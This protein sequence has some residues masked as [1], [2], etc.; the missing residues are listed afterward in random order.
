MTEAAATTSTAAGNTRGKLGLW[1]CLALVVGNIIGSGIFLLPASLAPYGWNSVVGWAMTAAGAMFLA[2]VFAQLARVFPQAGGP[3]VYPRVAFGELCGFLMAWGYWVSTWVGNVSIAI[4]TVAS[5]AELI[6]ALKTTVGAPAVTAVAMI[7]V[8]TLLNYR[9]VKFAGAF[10]FV[11]TILKLLPLLAIIVLAVWLF[12]T[13]DASVI[14]VAPQPLS[15]SS[16]TAAATLTLWALLGLE[17][18]T[19]PSD[20]VIDPERTVPRATLWGTLLAAVIYVLACSTVVLLLPEAEL[21]K[22]NAPFADAI[23]LFWGDAAASTLAFF[24]FVSGLGAL[25]GWILL[26]GEMPRVLAAE[27]VFP[28]I[29][30]KESRFG[31]PGAAFFITSALATPLALM[32]YSRSMVDIFTFMILIATSAFLVMYLF[33]SL[34]A[35]KLAWNGQLGLAGRRLI[36]MLSVGAIATVYSIWTLYGAGSEA[37]WWT[38]VLLA[39]GLPVYYFVRKRP[40]PAIITLVATVMLAAVVSF[41]LYLKV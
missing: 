35:I 3:Y 13:H 39:A 30:A 32:N 28:R 18:A 16:V 11:T 20:K 10:Q 5:L 25:N 21:A 4:G 15:I 22:S 41:L 1:M 8:L 23:R 40:M 12:L 27:G 19:V 26:Q 36:W 17:S 2:V 38:I 7:W 6:P 9:G 31:T 24:A 29:F 14:R 37:F 33:C 34:A